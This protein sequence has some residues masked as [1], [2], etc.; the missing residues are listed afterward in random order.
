MQ[1]VFWGARGSLPSSVNHHTIREK[2]SKALNQSL[3][4]D[5]SSEA[6]VESFIDNDLSFDIKGGF[7]CNTSCV[8][9]KCGDEYVLCDSGSGLR[10][11]GTSQVEQGIMS[12]TYHIFMSHLHWDHINGFP[13]FTPAYIPGNTVHVYGFHKYLESAFVNQQ[14]PPSFPLPLDQMAADIHFHVLE[15][16][17]TTEVNG[18]T[19]SGVAQRHPGASWGYAF[20]KD[21]KKV[22]YSTDSEHQAEADAEDYHFIEFCKGADL[23]IFD[24]QY[25]LADHY[26]V[27]KSW[28]HSSNLVAVELAVRSQVKRLCLFHHEHTVSDGELEKFGADTR[29]YLEIYDDKSKLEIDLAYEGMLLDI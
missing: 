19:V 9:I 25:N 21:G 8:E 18:V 6:D 16:G 2:I 27:K 29:R 1:V 7:G 28:G 13:F 17:A 20:E 14:N 4:V 3:S 15:H 24:A 12:A 26:F 22:V 11:F 23:L 10:D 5:L